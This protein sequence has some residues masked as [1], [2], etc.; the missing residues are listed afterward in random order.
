MVIV[1]VL[2]IGVA[3]ICLITTEV[4]KEEITRVEQKVQKKFFALKSL[5]VDVEMMAS[6]EKDAEIKKAL[7]K[8]AERIK[9]SDPMSNDDLEPLEKQISEKILQL[10]STEKMP[11]LE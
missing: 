7:G 2:I 8:L 6:S 5:Q 9:Y 4:G 1:S 11:L 10:K 3:T